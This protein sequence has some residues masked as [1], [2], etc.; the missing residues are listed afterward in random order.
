MKKIL[1]LLIDFITG[2]GFRIK[3][4]Y[5]LDY[6][7]DITTGIYHKWDSS[8]TECHIN[9]NNT[10]YLSEYDVSLCYDLTPCKYCIK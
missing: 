3:Y 5:S 1:K 10:E 6:T 4:Y 9:T 8:L 2:K 7:V